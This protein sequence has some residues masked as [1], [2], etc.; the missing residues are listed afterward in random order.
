MN[1]V[2]EQLSLLGLNGKEIRV[3]TTLSTFGRMTMTRLASRAGLSRTTVDAIVRRLIKQ[4][5]IFQEKVVGHFEYKVELAEVSKQLENLNFKLSTQNS[6]DEKNVTS[7]YSVLSEARYSVSSAF[8][9][10]KG[11]RVRILMG[12]GDHG[13]KRAARR[14]SGYIGHV[15]SQRS[16]LE[17]V[18]SRH[19]AD[20][21][22]TENV[23]ISNK[24][25]Q[26]HVTLNIVPT[27]YTTTHADIFVFRDQVLTIDLLTGTIEHT[28]STHIVDAMKHLVDIACEIGWSVELTTWLSKT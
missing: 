27:S 12:Q 9:Y 17:V 15:A 23:R 22:R 16:R 4:G 24:A 26:N 2:I 25:L 1:F 21:I 19:V 14:L 7:V 28:V 8:E 11:E 5:L 20:V 6:S 18:V 13:D 10:Y 3:F